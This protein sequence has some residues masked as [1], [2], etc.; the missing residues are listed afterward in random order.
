VVDGGG[1][2]GMNWL[3]GGPDGAPLHPANRDNRVS[4]TAVAMVTVVGCLARQR[5]GT[6]GPAT[7]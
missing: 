3:V 4:M 2:D 1:S 6:I 5:R 7:L